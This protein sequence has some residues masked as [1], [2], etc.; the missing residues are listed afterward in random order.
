MRFRRVAMLALIPLAIG[1][2]CGSDSN[3][4]SNGVES[5][6]PE[7][8]LAAT[9]EALRRAKSFHMESTER[10]SSS[11]SVKADNGL[12]RELRLALRDRDASVSVVVVDGSF[13]INGNGAYWKKVDAGQG[14]SF[15]ADRWFKV[16]R[17]HGEDLTKALDPRTF[18]RCLLTEHG[19]LARGGTATVDG[20]RAVVIVD[21]GDRPGSAPGKLYVA[22]TGEPFPLRIIATGKQ[23]PGGH[24]DPEC[25]DETPP[26]AGDEVIFSDYNEPLDVSAPPDAVDLGSGTPS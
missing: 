9:A 19:S 11:P 18:S 16:P 7:E 14:A 17:S 3:D 6:P 20:K 1:I 2:G 10:G 13:Y 4:G 5:K 21:K 15:L 22:A 12:P 8:I 26:S 25:G 24:K 23:R